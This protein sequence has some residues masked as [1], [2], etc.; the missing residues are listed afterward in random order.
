MEIIVG[1]TAGFCFGVKNAVDKTIEE[2]KNKKSIYCI[3]ELVHNKLVTRKLEEKGVIFI[4]NIEEARDNV[5]IR[6]HGVPQRTYQK[7]KELNLNVKDLTC[8]KVLHIHNIAKEYQDRDYFIFL[9]GQKDHPETIG[10]IS[11]CGE[12]AI[13]IEKQEDISNAVNEFKKTNKK[14]A[15]VIAQTTF[16]IE[17]FNS[18][19]S[20][21]KGEIQTIE[22]KNTI[23]SATKQRQEE[24]IK[25]SKNVDTMIIIGGKHS[26]N[27]T[28][29]F[30]IA[31]EYCENVIFIES[32]EDLDLK[33]I[34][35]EH[36]VGIMAGASTPQKS[37]QEVVEILTKI[38]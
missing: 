14:K 31:T 30:D 2:L 4:D 6:A 9:I 26:S 16:S 3:G 7:A 13:I 22:V 25:L 37:I 1:K 20:I 33:Q 35:K 19:V 28:K 18:I 5:I 15:L 29:L 11:F 10:T 23:C 24:T 17:K 36:K 21:L 12:N 27:T 32:K 34:N 8:P 38:C